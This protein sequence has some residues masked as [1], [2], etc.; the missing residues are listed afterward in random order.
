MSNLYFY[1]VIIVS[2]VLFLIGV[3]GVL[4]R[5]N[6][7]GILMAIEIMFNAANINLVAFNKFMHLEASIGIIFPIFIITLA[8]AE[9]AVGLALILAIYRNIKSVNVEKMELLKW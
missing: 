6:A 1:T 9:T 7:I 2:L 8:A 5:R 4:T 3:Y